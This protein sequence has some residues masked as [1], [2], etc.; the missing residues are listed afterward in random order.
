MDLSHMRGGLHGPMKMGRFKGKRG[1]GGHAG[2]YPTTPNQPS[3][4]LAHFMF[5]LAK[6]V[7]EKAGGTSSTALFCQANQNLRGPHRALHMCAFQIGLYALGL[8]N[9]VSPNWTHRT[10]SSH[11]TW[12]TNQV[13]ELGVTALKFIIGTWE[14]HLTPSEVTSVADKASKSRVP[15]KIRVGADLALSVLRF[16][17]DLKPNEIQRAIQQCKEDSRPRSRPEEPSMLEKACINVENASREGRDIHHDVMFEVARHWYSLYKKEQPAQEDPQA[18]QQ[19]HQDQQQQQHHQQQQQQQHQHQQQQQVNMLLAVAAQQQQGPAAGANF[20]HPPPGPPLGHPPPPPPQPPLQPFPMVLPGVL[21][22][23][24]PA[25]AAAAAANQAMAAAMLVTPPPN[26]QQAALQAAAAANPFNQ[27]YNPSVSTAAVAAAAAARINLQ[28]SPAGP[29]FQLNLAPLLPAPPPANAQQA[30][31][32]AMIAAAAAGQQNPQQA[33]A[34]VVAAAAAGGRHGLVAPQ[35]PNGPLPPHHPPH[36]QAPPA[37]AVPHLGVDQ[38]GPGHGA[39]AQ[40][41][42]SGHRYLELAYRVGLLALENLGRKLNEDRPQ[43]KFARNPSYGDDVKWLMNQ[44]AFKLGYQ[45]LMHFLDNV[46]SYI[47][48]PFLV[49]VIVN[50]FGISRGTN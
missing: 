12:I 47:L 41:N 40:P 28:Q 20:A 1:H 17:G 35:G 33:A 26:Q 45:S 5:E 4:A 29:I 31:H 10:Y 37:P 24:F 3:E 39:M 43:E 48:S 14:G 11:V 36:L 19:Q 25:A 21:I 44:V 27:V 8:H 32:Q 9:S 6:K 18:A 2:G 46:T 13:D 38:G 30:M 16:A 50:T 7:M 49:Q 22:P 23:S 34:A 42:P 15:A